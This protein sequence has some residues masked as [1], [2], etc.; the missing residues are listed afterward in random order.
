[1]LP[2]IYRSTGTA[3][4]SRFTEALVVLLIVGSNAIA[5]S[6]SAYNPAGDRL[7][8]VEPGFSSW[9]MSEIA[10]SRKQA[11][12]PA[13]LAPPT[14][15]YPSAPYTP[16]EI[17]VLDL[18]VA[19][20]PE[21]SQPENEPRDDRPIANQAAATGFDRFGVALCVLFV[22]TALV[23]VSVIRKKGAP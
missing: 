14:A 17:T 19:S 7:L 21:S 10:A 13:P 8:G 9:I 18:D 11:S 4:A 16:P 5:Q 12:N 15:L 20:L 22:L 2:F 3:M 6:T 23:G 1:M